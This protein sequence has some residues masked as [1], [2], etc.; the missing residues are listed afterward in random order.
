MVLRRVALREESNLVRTFTAPLIFT[1]AFVLS[2]QAQQT[3]AA[4]A[5]PA[6]QPQASAPTPKPPSA[7]PAQ[8]ASAPA[9]KAPN[10]APTTPP[11][12]AS[13]QPAM[14]SN[15]QSAEA[16]APPKTEEA[17]P[18]PAA[19]AAEGRKPLLAQRNPDGLSQAD[20]SGTIE[21]AK[22]DTKRL[23]AKELEGRKVRG[24]D[25][26]SL[27]TVKDF[28][29]DSRTNE[30][31]YAA[32]SSGGLFQRDYLKLIPFKALKPGGA[33]QDEFS[34]TFT[35]AEWNNLGTVD[36]TEFE[37]GRLV[38]LTSE[39]SDIARRFEHPRISPAASANDDGTDF[40]TYL[41]CA[42]KLRGRDVYFDEK[43]V[44]KIDDIVI[45]PATAAAFALLDPSWRL[46]DTK[47]KF[48]VPL[49]RYSFGETKNEPAI[50]AITPADFDR[51][52]SL[53]GEGEPG[54]PSVAK[55]AAAAQSAAKGK[56][57][58]ASPAQAPAAPPAQGQA[59]SAAA[60][61]AATPKAPA[62][63]GKVAES[64]TPSQPSAAP[65]QAKEASS[66]QANAPQPSATG[67]T[68][69]EQ[70]PAA[71]A[72]SL[73][74]AKAIR[75]ALDQDAAAAQI[76]VDVNA[77]NESIVLRGTVANP[78]AKKTIEAKAAQTAKGAKI[79]SQI[80]VGEI[81]R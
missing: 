34:V 17:G 64:Q 37:S 31:C 76:E 58:A 15:G 32:V 12:P 23:T 77:A 20:R 74:A 14:A 59:S 41:W 69:A 39:R 5:P 44:G 56:T 47:D 66:S 33:H 43:R 71:P 8:P 2:M 63:N 22:R 29:V 38:M 65:A 50:L 42:S 73:A 1:A 52:R 70:N 4:P 24:S 57:A 26:K 18:P 60:Q 9:Q 35:T 78:E 36:G 40:S 11:S 13:T 27:G 62:P 75:K 25:G 28:I 30:A 80:G 3:P 68:S 7:T 81:K 61:P 6:S 10:A 54:A 55:A 51:M 53:T 21:V 72:G 79:E 46:S 16:K 67:K 19:A 45:D 49:N 48:I